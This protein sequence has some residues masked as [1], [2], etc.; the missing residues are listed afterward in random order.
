VPLD[1]L[2]R[3]IF[4][5]RT[6]DIGPRKAKRVVRGPGT[7]SLPPD[8]L[9]SNGRKGGLARARLPNVSGINLAPWPGGG[10]LLLPTYLS[11]FGSPGFQSSPAIL[12]FA[13]LGHFPPFLIGLPR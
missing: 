7:I 5:K 12:C 8:Q 3:P 6:P 4:E 11:A 10:R 9:K 2:I 1:I 13:D